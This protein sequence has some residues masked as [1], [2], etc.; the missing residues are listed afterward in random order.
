MKKTIL[1]T[2]IALFGT[3]ITFAQSPNYQ[4]IIY[5]TPTGAGTHSGDSWANAT[6]S[7]A[8][9]QTLAQTHN[10]DV[11]VAEG[12]YYGDTTMDNAFTMVEGV[13]VY[14]GFAGNEPLNF[15]L[16]MRDFQNHESV[17]D[18]QNSQRVLQQPSDFGSLTVWDGFT[19]RNGRVVTN[20]SG[21]RW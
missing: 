7:I 3:A 1:I 15:N 11:W 21:Y 16:A 6:S 17:L 5:V 10:A 2:I 20:Y 14:G 8:Q 19:I 9:A 13:D 18:G 12:I 4:D